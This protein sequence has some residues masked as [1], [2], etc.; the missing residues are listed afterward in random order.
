[1]SANPTDIEKLHE[2]L[3]FEKMQ[4]MIPTITQDVKSKEVLMLAYVNRE[5][6]EMTLK[7]GLMHYWS[8]SR[9]QLWRKGEESGNIQRV[10]EGYFDCDGDALL[11][12]V[13][14]TGNCCHTGKYS[15]F[16]NR[17]TYVKKDQ[18]SNVDSSILDEVFDVILERQRNPTEG[19]YVA[20][21]LSQGEDQILRKVTE[22]TTELVLA[23]KENSKDEI[24]HEAADLI[25]HVM[26]LLA[27]KRINIGEVFGELKKRMK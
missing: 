14:Q 19:S 2:K 7:T 8:R 21:L 5:A 27:S 25:F 17:I 15:C 1:M 12:K 18:P 24:I 22:E 6:L 20:S 10:R 16:H 3:D 11:F 13:E 9:D 4:D 26:V 23:S